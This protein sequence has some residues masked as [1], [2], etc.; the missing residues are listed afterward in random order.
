[1]VKNLVAPRAEIKNN[2][3]FRRVGL[4]FPEKIQIIDIQ[5]VV[6]VNK[7]AFTHD[8]L[9]V[10]FFDQRKARVWLS[11]FDKNF[12][13]VMEAMQNKLPGLISFESLKVRVPFEHVEKVL[14]ERNA[15]N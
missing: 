1:M 14:W 2:T 7:D 12:R 5:S 15:E 10:V 13:E 11:E 4:F 6:A 3:L 9:V 8:E